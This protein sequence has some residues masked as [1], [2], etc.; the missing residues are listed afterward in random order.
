[1]QATALLSKA[2][3]EAAKHASQC[4]KLEADIVGYKSWVRELEKTEQAYLKAIRWAGAN[5]PRL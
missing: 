3:A 5:Y 1:M 4:S 2:Q